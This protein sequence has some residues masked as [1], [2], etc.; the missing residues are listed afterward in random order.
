MPFNLTLQG[1]RKLIG[2]VLP[3]LTSLGVGALMLWYGRMDGTQ[4]NELVE[5]VMKTGFFSFAGANAV[6]HA[7]NIFKRP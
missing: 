4:F 1:K 3:M 2:I 7:A 5:I 6:E